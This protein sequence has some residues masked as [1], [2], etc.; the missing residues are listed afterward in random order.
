MVYVAAGEDEHGQGLL[1]GGTNFPY[2]EKPRDRKWCRFVECPS[3][4]G[5][6]QREDETSRDVNGEVVKGTTF[7]P[8]PGNAVYWENLR[9]EDGSAYKETWHAGLPVRRGVKVGLNVWSWLEEP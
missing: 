3:E 8:I 4:A 6:Q 5:T 7:K 9:E 2:L 1:G